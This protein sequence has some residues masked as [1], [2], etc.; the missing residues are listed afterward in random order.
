MN[1]ETKKKPTMFEKA[2]NVYENYC[3]Y[4]FESNYIREI[5]DRYFDGDPRKLIKHIEEPICDHFDDSWGDYETG[6]FC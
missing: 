6:D 3:G 2:K 4:K 5:I 1:S